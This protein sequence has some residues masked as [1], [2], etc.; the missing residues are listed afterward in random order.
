MDMVGHLEL[1]AAQFDPA[2]ASR[3]ECDYAIKLGRHCVATYMSII[4]EMDALRHAKMEIA[5]RS[6]T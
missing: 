5:L 4:E 1:P 3:E 2:T 6:T